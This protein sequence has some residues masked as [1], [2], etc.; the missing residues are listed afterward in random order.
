MKT[1]QNAWNS[2]LRYGEINNYSGKSIRIQSTIKLL[3]SVSF[4]VIAMI[5]TKHNPPPHKTTTTMSSES[6]LVLA[7][8]QSTPN[9]LKKKKMSEISPFFFSFFSSLILQLQSNLAM[10][11]PT[12]AENRGLW[13]LKF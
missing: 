6:S 9:C 3:T 1:V 2:Y 13:R 12:V 7:Q 4:S 11:A 8:R 5:S 10:L